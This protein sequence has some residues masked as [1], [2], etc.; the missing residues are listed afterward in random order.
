MKVKVLVYNLAYCRSASTCDM[1]IV[2]AGVVRQGQQRKTRNNTGRQ[3]GNEK[4]PDVALQW[5]KKQSCILIRSLAQACRVTFASRDRPYSPCILLPIT[6]NI[7]LIETSWIKCQLYISGV[8]FQSTLMTRFDTNLS[9]LHHNDTSDQIYQLPCMLVFPRT[10][11][12]RYWR[13]SYQNYHGD[14]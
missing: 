1:M 12:S 7:L 10:L 3:F 5:F 4:I 13:D 11:F 6:G 2:E 14:Y 8:R 9:E